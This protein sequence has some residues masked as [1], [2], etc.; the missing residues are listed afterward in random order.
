M[1]IS[2]ETE[3]NDSD[4]TNIFQ[5]PAMS[6]ALF[7]ACFQSSHNALLIVTQSLYFRAETIMERLITNKPKSK[8]LSKGT[9]LVCG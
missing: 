5:T 8:T 3:N 1:T 4:E 9:Q 6:Q 7:L 2:F